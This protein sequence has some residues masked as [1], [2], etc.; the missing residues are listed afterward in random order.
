MVENAPK[1]L[2][3]RHGV[4]L[5]NVG[6][7]LAQGSIVNSLVQPE[8]PSRLQGHAFVLRLTEVVQGLRGHLGGREGHDGGVLLPNVFGDGHGPSF[9]LFHDQN[10]LAT[11]GRTLHMTTWT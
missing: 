2:H 9:G 7:V 3:G 6:L 8:G 11:I 1:A 4:N 10:G 5:A